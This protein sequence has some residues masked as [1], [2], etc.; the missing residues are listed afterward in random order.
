MPPRP[1]R[2]TV[3][4]L[5]LRTAPPVPRVPHH[6]PQDD[7]DHQRQL[8]ASILNQLLMTYLMSAA[9]RWVES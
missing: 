3:V 6:V 8:Y 4:F 7:A 1:H 5:V 9:G 2:P